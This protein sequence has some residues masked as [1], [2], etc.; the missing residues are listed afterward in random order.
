MKI[1]IITLF[2]Q[3]FD[4][5]LNSSI[6]KRAQKKG[7]IQFKFI[8]LRDFGEGKHQVVD[9][10]PYGG[11]AGMILKPDVLSSALE[12][13]KVQ[14]SKFKVVLTS[15]NGKPYKQSKAKELSKLDHLVIVCG[16]YEGIDQRFID[17]YA[18]EEIS[19]GDYV[20]TGG[21][22]PAMV[23]IDSITRLIPGVLEKPEAVINESFTENFLEGPQY[24]RPKVFEGKIVP[25]VLL[26]GNH[27]KIAKWRTQK[28]LAKTKKVRPDLLK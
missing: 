15:A 11:G 26:S 1:S 7:K 22:I 18:D 10:R 8:N 5:I 19:I 17:K 4:P 2:P 27:A 28:S 24:T 3:V 21:E 23:I 16:H 9:G 13:F 20:L 6:L 14:S 25:K 12:K